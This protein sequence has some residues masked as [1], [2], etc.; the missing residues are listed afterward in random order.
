MTTNVY[1]ARAFVHIRYYVDNFPTQSGVCLN[2]Y[3]WRMMQRLFAKSATVPPGIKN[4]IGKALATRTTEG[5]KI[6]RAVR[7]KENREVELDLD[8]IDLILKR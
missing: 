5:F 3:E 1:L 6:E 2:M 7:S 4:I 8:T